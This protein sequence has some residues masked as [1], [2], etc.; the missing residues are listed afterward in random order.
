M[1]NVKA[2]K[3]EKQLSWNKQQSTKR[4]SIKTD[5]HKT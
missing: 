1:E 2:I 4:N 5:Q 3:T